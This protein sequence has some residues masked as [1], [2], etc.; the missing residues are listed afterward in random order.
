MT[1]PDQFSGFTVD[2]QVVPSLGPVHRLLGT[3]AAL[4]SYH[5]VSIAGFSLERHIPAYALRRRLRE[6]LGWIA[7]LAVP[8]M[9]TGAPVIE[10]PGRAAGNYDVITWSADYSHRRWLRML[11]KAQAA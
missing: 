1:A 8:G 4:A 7:G 2:D 10:V 5:S 3:P 6:R 9:P 11:G